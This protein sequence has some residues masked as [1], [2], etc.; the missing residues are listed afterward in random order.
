[1]AGLNELPEL[2]RLARLETTI[3]Q[4]RT[5]HTRLRGRR[6]LG[7]EEVWI[8]DSII[9]QGGYGQ[10]WL[11][12]KLDNADRSKPKLRAVKCIH[13]SAHRREYVRELDALATFSSNS[14]KVCPLQKT[15]YTDVASDM[16]WQYA[17]FF[18]EFYG[19]YESPGWL[20]AAME[21]C[22]HGDLK[23]YLQS[24]KTISE[25]EAQ[26][27][28]L[29]VLGGLSLMHEAGFAH[30]DVKPGVRCPINRDS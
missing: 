23:N 27:I 24:H 17:E 18:V 4:D 26:E 1:M 9:G 20:H 13:A 11:E 3:Q 22:K 30:R 12:R 5:I 21:Y 10:V 19:W 15:K 25:R 8:R 16:L 28:I 29:Q 6:G 2:V 7:S 14:N